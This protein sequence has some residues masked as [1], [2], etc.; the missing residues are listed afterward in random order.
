MRDHANAVLDALR[1]MR[2][3]LAALECAVEIGGPNVIKDS[4]VSNG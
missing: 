4:P 1:R 3:Q 2:D